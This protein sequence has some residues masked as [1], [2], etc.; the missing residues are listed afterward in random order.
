MDEHDDND[1]MTIDDPSLLNGSYPDD[2]VLEELSFDLAF[3][4]TNDLVAVGNIDGLIDW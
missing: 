4:P 2:I 1:K 3:S